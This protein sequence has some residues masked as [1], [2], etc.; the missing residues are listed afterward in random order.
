MRVTNQMMANSLLANTNTLR[1][2]TSTLMD[3]ISSG[4]RINRSSEDPTAGAEVM[5]TQSRLQLHEQWQTN[6]NNARIWTRETETALGRMTGL[7]SRAKELAIAGSSTSIG[8]SARTALAPEVRGIMEDMMAM[9]NAKGPDGY[10]FGGDG[11]WD[12]VANQFVNQPPFS[13]ELDVNGDPTGNFL[14]AGTSGEHQRS[15]GPGIALAVNLHGNR[16]G[17]SGTWDPANNPLS[18]VFKLVQDLE[19]GSPATVQTNLDN[20]DQAIDQVI[21]LRA[22][23]GTREKRLEQLESQIQELYVH[24]NATLVQAQGVDMEKAIIDLTSAETTYRA[25]LQV[26]ARIIP[27]TLADFLR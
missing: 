3:Q 6:Q 5:R 27:P 2:R 16:I 17:D 19:N 20:L 18:M 21:S 11:T 24:L 8:D 23:M 1:G 26:G 7:L 14:Y 25:A 4:K 15:V 22:E 12:A 13:M 9:L 10:L